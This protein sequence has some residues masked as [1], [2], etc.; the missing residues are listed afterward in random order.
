[1]SRYLKFLHV[2]IFWPL[3]LKLRCFVIC[4]FFG[5]KMIIFVL[6]AFRFIL[7]ARNQCHIKERSRFTCPLIFLSQL[8]VNRKFVSSAQQCT[9]QYSAELCMSLMKRIHKSG[10]STEP[11]G[12]P[13]DT[14]FKE[15]SISLIKVYCILSQRGNLNQLYNVHL[16]A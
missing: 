8:S 14:V 4:W 7:L 11:C 15:D 16:I 10:P 3:I 2:L 12:T 1:M 9:L 5:R 6:L 13:W